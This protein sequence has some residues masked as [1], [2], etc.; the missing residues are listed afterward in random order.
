MDNPFADLIP[1]GDGQH[2]ASQ[3]GQPQGINPFADLIPQQGQQQ[4]QQPQMPQDRSPQWAQSLANSAPV[5]MILGAGDVTQHMLANLADMMVPA[6]PMTGKPDYKFPQAESGSGLAYQLGKIGGY[7]MPYTGALKGTNIAL[8]GM[9]AAPETASLLAKGIMPSMGRNAIA[10]AGLGALNNPDNRTTGALEEG[11][12]GG[13][14]AGAFEGAGKAVSSLKP[15]SYF[16]GTLSPEQLQQNV[17]VSRGTSTPLGDIIES[18]YLKRLYENNLS[19]IVTS[20]ADKKMAETADTVSAKGTNILDNYL[21]K[22]DPSQVESKLGDALL[23]AYKDQNSYKNSLYQ[24]AEKIADDIKMPVQISKFNNT[25]RDNKELIGNLKLDAP[26]QQLLD[27]AM[28]PPSLMAQM[29]GKTNAS[30]L[31]LKE[32]NILAGSLKGLANQYKSPLPADKFMSRQ[33]SDLGSALKSDIS[34]SID[35][36]GSSELKD[37]FQSAEKNYKEN[38]SKFLDKDIHQYI[39]GKKTAE[40]LLG[41]FV[42]TGKNTDKSIQLDKLMSKL[43]PDAQNL[44]KYSYLSRAIKGG[45]DNRYVDPHALKNLWSDNNLGQNQKRALMPDKAERQTMDDFSKLVSMNGEALGRMFNPKTGQ[46][47]LE[48]LG[49]LTNLFTAGTGAALGGIP[50][51]TAA[52]LAKLGGSRALTSKLT[53]EP[54]REK[55][56]QKMIKG[57]EKGNKQNY[58]SDIAAA[59]ANALYNK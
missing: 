17:N 12:L 9:E 24:N 45:E 19:K 35:K 58:G 8:R 14:T 32:A 47:G 38:Y 34:S 21:G 54:Y 3:Q 28:T 44:A 27:K 48:G 10:S 25:L 22:T 46:R 5:N 42:K 18:P 59:L 39:S 53:S 26:T 36:S 33:I 57:G 43:P 52:M 6:N 55:F 7:A 49:D 23:G 1:Q 29:S 15:T 50:G 2:P 4:N 41:T 31:S 37:A 40:D 56:V 20:G 11:A 16:R 30:N 13:L 51:M